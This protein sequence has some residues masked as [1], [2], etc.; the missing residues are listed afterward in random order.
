M[1]IDVW[2]KV[3][4]NKEACDL[5]PDPGSGA[6]ITRLSGSMVAT[7]N[8]YLPGG[9][10]ANGR[11]I[12]ATRFLDPLVS[13]INA[14]MAIDL[15]TKWTALLDPA[16]ADV[17]VLP[18]PFT[19]V[20]YYVNHQMEVCRVSLDTFDKE[21][22]LNLRGMPP[23]DAILRGVTPDQ[24]YLFYVTVVSIAA[25]QSMA[26]VRL[27]VPAKSWQ[28][29]YENP[30]LTGVIYLPGPNALMVGRRTMADGSTP[31][32]GAWK[33]STGIKADH[34]LFD[35]DG[36][37]LRHLGPAAG[38]NYFDARTGRVV[39]NC[40]YDQTRWAQTPDR[41]RG[42]M[43]VFESLDMKM[44]RVIDAPDH[45]FHHIAGSRCGRYVVSEALRPG[46]GPFGPVDIVVVNWHTGKH[47]VLVDNCGALGSGG[48]NVMRQPTPYLTS[49]N[50]HVVY[51]ADPDGI[52]NVYSAK[53]PDG[54]LAS[55]D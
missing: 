51:N 30:G 47:R 13:P 11:R 36:K 4:W 1:S 22:V 24:R 31:P 41:P 6:A 2:T 14:L 35:L 21:V 45:L 17:H 16:L 53:L 25:G 32:L 34:Q 29:I 37:F 49:D 5:P 8:N 10:S 54:F 27:D 20:C 18:V 39:C 15:D 23:V 7:N 19:G 33:N 9:C 28:M 50:S 3:P 40:Y 48:G 26:I 46:T 55:L 42:N 38:Y 44:E 52:P 12:V 43:V